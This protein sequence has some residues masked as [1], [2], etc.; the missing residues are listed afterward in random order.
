M[1]TAFQ[2]LPHP[3]AHLALNGPYCILHS[4]VHARPVKTEFY[5]W[6]DALQT[7]REKLIC[8]G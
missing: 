7:V 6:P 1:V 3:A 2:K 4:L 5:P 8:R